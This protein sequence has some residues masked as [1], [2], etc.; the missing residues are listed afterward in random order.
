MP[1]FLVIGAAKSGTTSLYHYLRQHPMVFMSDRKEIRFFNHYHAAPSYTGPGAD[2]IYRNL[3]SD[4]DEY[5]SLF[6]RAAHFS[7]RGEASN[8][9]ASPESA[10][11]IR[12]YI[13]DV[14]II[15]LLRNPAERAFSQFTANRRD[16]FEPEEDFEWALELEAER[17]RLNW[18]PPWYYRGNGYYYQGLKE[19]YK[20]FPSE[21]I[22][23]VLTEDMQ[24]DAI[25]LC[26]E[27]FQHLGVDQSF[28]PATSTRYNVSGIPRAR[29]LYRMLA[30]PTRINRLG[31][32]LL[33]KPLRSRIRSGTIDK[34]MVKIPLPLELRL[35]LQED[36]RE[37]TL[38]LQELL[39][40]DLVS[41]LT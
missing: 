25:A 37:D 32:R 5:E 10:A 4:V 8:Y 35:K 2:T 17:R 33:S 9:L 34:G 18:G 16:G 20:L 21:Q 41:W 36:Y 40:R 29:L 11:R 3:V 28:T 31:K 24:N 39:D 30:G 26:R 22:K 19:F 27:I 38:R 23:V 13:P 7:A 12:H 14:R 1:N 15:A 6:A